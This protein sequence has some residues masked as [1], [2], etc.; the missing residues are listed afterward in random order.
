MKKKGSLTPPKLDNAII[1]N[2]NDNEVHVISKN[3]LNDYKNDQ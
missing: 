3:F 2:T 1:T